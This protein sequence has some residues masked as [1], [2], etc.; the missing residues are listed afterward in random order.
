MGAL[1]KSVEHDQLSYLPKK[2]SGGR[3]FQ[4]RNV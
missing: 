2:E 1:E 4:K 3:S